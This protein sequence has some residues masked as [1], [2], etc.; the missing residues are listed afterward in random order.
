MIYPSS[1]LCSQ[2]NLLNR[3]GSRGYPSIGDVVIGI[4]KE[5]MNLVNY[6]IILGKTYLW[7]CMRKGIKPNF[8]HFQKMLDL[9]YEIKHIRSV[10]STKNGKY[11]KDII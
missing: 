6:I 10:G 3:L 9:K 4:L 1:F 7:T 5:G 11:F 2:L 8:E